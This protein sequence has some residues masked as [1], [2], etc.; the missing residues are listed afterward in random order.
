MFAQNFFLNSG[1]N[2]TQKN[3]GFKI[4]KK[5]EHLERVNKQIYIKCK[6]KI[7]LKIHN[8]IVLKKST[9]ELTRLLHF[10]HA[11]IMHLIHILYK[12]DQFTTS[13][14]AQVYIILTKAYLKDKNY[15]V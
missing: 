11:N 1:S 5:I 15:L 7:T 13:N 8:Y 9:Q 2:F 6:A 10:R 14:W 3:N 4:N 12:K